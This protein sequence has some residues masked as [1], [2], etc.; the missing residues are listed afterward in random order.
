MKEGEE[1]RPDR[2]R[3]RREWACE[4][5]LEESRRWRMREMDWWVWWKALLQRERDLM[6]G[7][8]TRFGSM[9]VRALFV[10]SGILGS[11]EERAGANETRSYGFSTFF[12]F[13]LAGFF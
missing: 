11:R 4:S 7:S 6:G 9:R 10:F 2:R 1:I 13:L 3:R 5:I 8:F 12:F